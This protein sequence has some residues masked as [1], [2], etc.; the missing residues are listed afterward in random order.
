MTIRKE[1]SGETVVPTMCAMHCGGTCVLKVYVKDG[2][3]T[4]I[5]T[6]DGE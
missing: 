3:I 4:R 5:E 6:D 1:V 2:V